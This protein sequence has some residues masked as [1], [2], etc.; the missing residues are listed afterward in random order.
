MQDGAKA[1]MVDLGLKVP[2]KVPDDFE[3][4][5]RDIVT[6]L[7]YSNKNMSAFYDCY[8]TDESLDNIAKKY[9][10]TSKYLKNLKKD[11][12]SKIKDSEQLAKYYDHNK[13]SI[14]S[15]EYVRGFDEGYN[16][17]HEDAYDDGYSI[18]RNEGYRIGYQDGL[19]AALKCNFDLES[20]IA[21]VFPDT[22]EVSAEPNILIEEAG[23]SA[24]LSN[25]LQRAGYCYVEEVIGA[26]AEKIRNIR[27]IGGTTYA[28]LVDTLVMKYNEDPTKWIE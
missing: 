23:F 11:I 8:F 1:L 27:G 10:Y 2:K 7:N 17:G 13:N 26:G 21:E 15:K 3:S 12:C 18:G 14:N 28:E 16:A 22:D 19:Q 20:I 6:E 4:T 24:R 5:I 25:A 9:L